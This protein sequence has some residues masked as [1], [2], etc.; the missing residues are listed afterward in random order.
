MNVNS[1]KYNFLG[2][3]QDLIII[4]LDLIPGTILDPNPK[5]FIF[6]PE[7][8]RALSEYE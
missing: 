3:Y 1:K 5:N 8:Y 4:I 2:K 7:N 6:F